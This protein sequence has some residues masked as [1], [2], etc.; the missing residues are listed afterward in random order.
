MERSA[1]IYREL[2]SRYPDVDQSEHERGNSD[3]CS[4]AAKNECHTYNH[5]PRY[6]FIV[7]HYSWWW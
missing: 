5:L 2:L 6:I 3:I 4:F 7:L 1:F